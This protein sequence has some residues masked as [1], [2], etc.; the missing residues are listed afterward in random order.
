MPAGLPKLEVRFVLDADGILQVQAT[1]L[2]SAVSTHIEVKPQYGLTD[3][4]VETMLLDSLTNAKTDIETRLLV[5]VKTEADQMIYLT[6]QFLSKHG[7]TVNENEKLMTLSK[8]E[9]LK[10]S[11]KN[12]DRHKISEKIDSLNEYTKPFAERAMNKAISK[13]L[14]GKKI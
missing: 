9:E 13:S 12:D 7:D 1:E 11:L 2:R 8:M 6:E 4:Q 14:T 5:E 3:T 10:T